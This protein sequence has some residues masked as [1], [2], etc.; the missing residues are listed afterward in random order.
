MSKIYNIANRQCVLKE[1]SWWEVVSLLADGF[2]DSIGDRRKK[3]LCFH[4]ESDDYF[5]TVA[6]IIDLM[7][8]D[9]KVSNEYRWKILQRL[10][11]DLLFLQKNYRICRKIKR[12]PK[13]K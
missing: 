2:E 9:T 12:E 8:Q 7:V 3:R 6:T 4:I 13:V 5:G 11:D 1:A 10:R